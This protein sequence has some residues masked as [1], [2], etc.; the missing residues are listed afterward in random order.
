MDQGQRSDQK[1]DSEHRLHHLLPVVANRGL[2]R[3]LG[4]GVESGIRVVEVG[5]G[6]WVEVASSQS[7]SKWFGFSILSGTSLVEAENLEWLSS[8]VWRGFSTV[9]KMMYK[10]VGELCLL[11]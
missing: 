11:A 7:G 4:V 1:H 6:H 10:R 8:P 2:L 5:I 3:V 9:L